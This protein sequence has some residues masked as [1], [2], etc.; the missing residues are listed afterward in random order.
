MSTHKQSA[1]SNLIP[2]FNQIS[3]PAQSH[4][5]P[6]S[7]TQNSSLAAPSTRKTRSS[8]TIKPSAPEI[9]SILCTKC[10]KHVSYLIE[11]RCEKCRSD[12]SE[13]D[14][15]VV[16]EIS[17]NFI[18]KRTKVKLTNPTIEET[19]A[20]R[21]RAARASS[22]NRKQSQGDNKTEQ[23]KIVVTI[24]KG[25]SKTAEKEKNPNKGSLEGTRT[26]RNKSGTKLKRKTISS[27]TSIAVQHKKAKLIKAKEPTKKKNSSK[28]L[29]N[30]S[31]DNNHLDSEDK[32]TFS[33]KQEE[34][35]EQVKLE[36]GSHLE[37][38]VDMDYLQVNRSQGKG[39]CP[40]SASTTTENT[41][42][43]LN[44]FESV[45]GITNE[46]NK[47]KCTL[48][49]QDELIRGIHNDVDGK[50]SVQL[51]EEGG[52]KN[53][54]K[55]DNGEERWFMF[56]EGFDIMI[57]CHPEEDDF[58]NIHEVRK[59][60]D[61]FVFKGKDSKTIANIESIVYPVEEVIHVG[62]EF[63]S[64]IP[65]LMEKPTVSRRV[66]LKE[67][68]NPDQIDRKVYEE[69]VTKVTQVFNTDK[70]KLNEEKT[71][72]LLTE[73]S[74]EADKAIKFIKANMDK[75]RRRLLLTRRNCV[76]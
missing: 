73:Y 4:N 64:E 50:S 3:S 65:K 69:F 26:K 53:I 36:V 20:K 9:M 38:K 19:V 71:I 22:S 59:K 55:K 74:Y 16:V 72:E 67:I 12:L 54:L 47:D 56:N 48:F 31:N 21:T 30:S 75:C 51:A 62:D 2:Q 11:N 33:V 5:N 66:K 49:D 61:E 18:P 6:L 17:S 60:K 15:D 46:G 29:K 45:A 14:E 8:S 25:N 44:D 13:P 42:E 27:T 39:Q 58:V 68:W 23:S 28:Q 34:E 37:S 70:D 52:D 7:S 32:E 1:L 63:Q 35:F 57:G 24:V 43:K 40:L 41:I 10:G 76:V